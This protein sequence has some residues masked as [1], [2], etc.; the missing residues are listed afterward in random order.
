MFVT[1]S[2]FKSTE[3]KIA[4]PLETEFSTAKNEVSQCDDQTLGFIVETLVIH[5]DQEKF[6]QLL[7]GSSASL[8][9][10]RKQRKIS[11]TRAH[12]VKV[13]KPVSIETCKTLCEPTSALCKAKTS[14]C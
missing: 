3:N 4:T 13:W 12:L 9:N 14:F 7:F 5:F 6:E 10:V 1:F 11:L 2:L 8:L